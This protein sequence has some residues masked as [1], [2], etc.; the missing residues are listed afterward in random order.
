MKDRKVAIVAWWNGDKLWTE[1]R[2]REARHDGYEIWG[3]ND[4]SREFRPDDTDRWYQLHSVEY[5]EKRWPWW[6]YQTKKVWLEHWEMGGVTPLYMQRHYP[7]LSGSVAF[8]KERIEAELPNGRYHCGSI[9]WMVA[10]ALLEGVTHLRLYGVNLMPPAEPFSS[11]PCLEYWL[12]VAAGR[13]VEV[14]VLYS[15]DIFKTFNLLKTDWAY[16]WDESRPVIDLDDVREALRVPGPDGSAL[17]ET[18]QKTIR[19]RST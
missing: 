16:A 10:H 1:G 5:L 3:L 6:E 2:W 8:P 15:G 18:L 12:G 14:E 13:G 4:P 17:E 11:R 7:D 9:D 19:T